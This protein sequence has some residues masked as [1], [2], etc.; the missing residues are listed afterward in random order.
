MSLQ[1]FFQD[2]QTI[3]NYIKDNQNATQNVV[4]FISRER[5]S[6]YPF[7]LG[8]FLIFFLKKAYF[9]SIPVQGGLPA[10]TG[11]ILYYNSTQ[12]SKSNFALEWMKEI[13]TAILQMRTGKDNATIEAGVQVFPIAKLRVSGF[14]VKKQNF[15][16]FFSLFSEKRWL[17]RTEACGSMFLR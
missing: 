4:L 6:K 3:T 5:Y 17:R 2:N 9:G 15:S 13:D 16:S 7:F 10:D 12:S 14:D 11:Y 1:G 8:N